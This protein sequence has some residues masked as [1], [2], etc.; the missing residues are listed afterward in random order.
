[1]ST[2]PNAKETGLNSLEPFASVVADL[3]CKSKSSSAENLILGM[4]VVTVY[5]LGKSAISLGVC[6][7]FLTLCSLLIWGFVWTVVSAFCCGNPYLKNETVI[8]I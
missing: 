6:L 8:I 5:P 2:F 4:F 1:M 3:Y 7:S